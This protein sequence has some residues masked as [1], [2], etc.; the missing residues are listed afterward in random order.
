MQCADAGPQASKSPRRR[1]PQKYTYSYQFWIYW[2]TLNQLFDNMSINMSN[3]SQIHNTIFHIVWEHFAL[4]KM[5]QLLYRASSMIHKSARRLQ[6]LWA[7]WKSAKK[8]ARPSL[9]D[10]LC[11]L[12]NRPAQNVTVA[13]PPSCL[14]ETTCFSFK[15]FLSMSAL[16]FCNGMSLDCR[17]FSCL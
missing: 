15:V 7:F 5:L 2:L 17:W 13:L 9:I 14:P 11:R 3:I 1:D 6:M 4:L 8:P 16:I 10:L 12:E